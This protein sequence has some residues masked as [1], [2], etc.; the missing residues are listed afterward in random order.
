MI[1]Q[2]LL[3]IICCPACKGYLELFKFRDFG[4]QTIM[5]SL[6]CKDCFKIYRVVD[7]IPVMITDD[8]SGE[9]EV[10]FIKKWK[11]QFPMDVWEKLK[12]KLNERWEKEL[13][14]NLWK[15]VKERVLNDD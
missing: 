9:K 6:V 10:V 4:K 3:Y 1:S 12:V 2:D 5:E 8:L 15:I 14:K 13:P 11:Q 7:D